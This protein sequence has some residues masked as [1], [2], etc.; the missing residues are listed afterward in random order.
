MMIL[1]V[2]SPLESADEKSKKQV[3]TFE[4]P[5]ASVGKLGLFW[6][7][8]AAYTVGSFGFV[9]TPDSLESIT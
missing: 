1:S 4:R 9:P 7:N 5:L 6:M 8:L 2:K 3:T